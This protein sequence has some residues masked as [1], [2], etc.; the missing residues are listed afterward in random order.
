M[1]RSRRG[2]SRLISL[3]RPVNY[4]ADVPGQLIEAREVLNHDL[5]WLPYAP[6]KYYLK[7]AKY[8]RSALF[9]GVSIPDQARDLTS[10]GARLLWAAAFPLGAALY[11]AEKG[12]FAHLLPGPRLRGIA[13]KTTLKRGEDPESIK[14]ADLVHEGTRRN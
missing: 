5:R 8:S 2:T 14:V 3:S 11:V 13:R 6:M 10:V 9:A 7:S 12:R 4:L 1:R